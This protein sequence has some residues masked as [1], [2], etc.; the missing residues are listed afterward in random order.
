M[1]VVLCLVWG[2]FRSSTAAPWETGR[3]CAGW[4]LRLYE[5]VCVLDGRTTRGGH[6]CKPGGL[7]T[8]TVSLD[9]TKWP[10]PSESDSF[11]LELVLWSIS[12][13][14]LCSSLYRSF[15]KTYGLSISIFIVSSLKIWLLYFRC[16]IWQ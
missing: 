15:G 14:S 6:Q 16:K 11:V 1:V 3:G 8:L 13:S 9:V 4:R 5:V 10:T 12:L 7:G 2:W